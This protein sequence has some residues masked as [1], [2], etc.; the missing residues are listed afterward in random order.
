MRTARIK[1]LEIENESYDEIKKA[2]RTAAAERV[3][4]RMGKL[5]VELLGK[6]GSWAPS[7]RDDRDILAISM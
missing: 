2:A 7:T 3:Q 5:R 6:G 4:V 1:N